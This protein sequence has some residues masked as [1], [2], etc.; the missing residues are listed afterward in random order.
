M[1][2]LLD[3]INYYARLGPEEVEAIGNN[4]KVN[5]YSKGH[6]LVHEGA[7]CQNLYFIL[8]GT[9]RTFHDDTK[10]EVTTWIYPEGHFITSWSSFLMEKAS[11]ES[12][13]VLEN[14]TEL[15]FIKKSSLVR[16][17]DQYR[18]IERF[19]RLLAEDQ[20][21]VIDDYARGY[22]FLSAK[23]KYETL[24][25]FFPDV[26]QRVNLGHVASLLGISQETLSRIRHKP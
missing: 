26:T 14:E 22:H 7:V 1:Q 4:F 15:A 25:S 6:L 23:E 13:Q 20:L 8:K 24:L 10:K 2:L 11:A 19:G 12:I 21:A 18:S 17:Y 5:T 3:T 9:C 16:L